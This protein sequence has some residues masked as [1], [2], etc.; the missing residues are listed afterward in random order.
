MTSA[1]LC[2]A[3]ALLAAAVEGTPRMDQEA[4]GRFDVEMKPLG[5]PDPALGRMS[6]SKRFHG[7][8]EATSVGEM[9]SAGSP[10]TGSA[11]YVAIE[12]VSG[13]LKGR[14]GG[15]ALQHRGTM[16]AGAQ[17]LSITVAPGSG[18]GAL[19]ALT[20]SMTIDPSA[21]HAYVFRYSLPGG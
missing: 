1:A 20:G 14:A 16:D 4:R 10:A 3:A 9:L 7:D 5:A 17:D 2:L 18:T 6:I 21:G 13:T 8:L 11:G 19:K 15:F 12:Q